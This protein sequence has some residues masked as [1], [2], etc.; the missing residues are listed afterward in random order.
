[1][2]DAFHL[3]GLLDADVERW[4]VREYGA[5]PVRLRFPVFAA[6]AV[7]RI[8][9]RLA[10]DG[11]NAIRSLP[12]D[13]GAIGRAAHRLGDAAD[14]LR[15]TAEAALPA[16]TG[17]S[18]AMVRLI[19]DRSARD[20]STA[21]SRELL[22]RE[23]PPGALE[24][25]V[26]VHGT[27]TRVMA[28]GP[29]L[30][31]HICSGNVPGVAVTSIIRSLLVRAPTLAKTAAGEPLL[32][33]LFARAIESVEPR[34]AGSLAVTHW[35]GGHSTVEDEAIAAADTIVVYGGA[36]TVRSLRRRVPARTRI[37]EHGPR[38]SVGLV[39][40][41]ALQ[42]DETARATAARVAWA[43]ALFDQ[44]GC[45]SPHVIWI[46][47]S[48]VSAD[49]FAALLGEALDRVEA[50][51]PRGSLDAAE[52]AAIR[53]VRT[54][55]EFR[56]IDGEDVTLYEGRANGWTVIRDSMPAF[57]PSC[58]NRTVHVKPLGRLEQAGELI[59]PL[60]GFVQSVAIEGAGERLEPVARSLADAGATRITD[61]GRMPWP[62]PTW[63]H[64]GAG[65]LRELVTWIDLET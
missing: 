45:V 4:E 7:A 22:G 54:R 19:L 47:D 10:S 49:R 6:G 64:D 55:A 31:L 61:F 51:L 52:A 30:A 43:V 33:V 53:D 39:G 46:E 34:L 15:R 63:H 38:V 35:P 40:H 3:P 5:A 1:M 18:S 26:P 11:G 16:V 50:E 24:R 48:P 58:L 25:F 27:P 14:P 21:R 60:R 56:A 23:I 37:V 32:A 8:A 36:D 42:T 29:R 17:Y 2:I 13:V 9:A 20:W 28:V 59:A 44:Q 12:L 41:G 62:P 57:E 65:P